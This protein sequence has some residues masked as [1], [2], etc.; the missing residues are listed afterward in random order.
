MKKKSAKKG[1]QK[2]DEFKNFNNQTKFLL[3]CNKIPCAPNNFQKG[4]S[5]RNLLTQS[6]NQQFYFSIWPQ[7]VQIQIQIGKH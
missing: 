5:L 7:I 2:Q 4:N 6:S 3:N 1:S